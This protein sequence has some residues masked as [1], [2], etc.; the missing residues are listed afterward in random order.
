VADYGNDRIQHFTASGTYLGQWGEKGSADGQFK[1]AEDVAVSKDGTVYVADTNNNRI[2]VFGT[3]YPTTWRG[4][5]FGNR[6]L[7]EQ[8]LLIEEQATLSLDWGAASPGDDVPPDDFS[9]RWQRYVYFETPGWYEFTLTV[10]GGARLWVGD[11]LLI[12]EWRAPQSATFSERLTL[13]PGY[14]RLRV[15]HY[16][17]TGTASLELTWANVTRHIYLPLALRDYV[18]YFEGPWEVEPNNTWQQ[19]NGPLLSDEEYYGYPNDDRDYFSIYTRQAGDITVNLTGHTG[20][21]VQL[22][23]WRG[24]PRSDYSNL[25]GSRNASPYRI[26]YTGPA[27][28]YYIYIYT[29]SGHNEDTPYTLRVTYPQ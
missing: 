10:E 1:Y 5:Y 27:G 2:Q 8:P 16:K 4:E 25:V 26:T 3:V 18:C 24:A 15:E 12:E 9:S 23:L 7:A 22:L 19:A 13:E 14:H 28:W 6:W 20:A 21:G 29:A 11:R 17:T